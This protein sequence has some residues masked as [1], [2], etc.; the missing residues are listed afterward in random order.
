MMRLSSW[1]SE[2][3]CKMD[4]NLLD[5]ECPLRPLDD[6]YCDDGAGGGQGE[7]MKTQPGSSWRFLQA[8]STWLA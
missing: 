2:H 1:R 3:S 5:G 6:K 4:T 7:G 8:N